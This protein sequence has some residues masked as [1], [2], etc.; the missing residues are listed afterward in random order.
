VPA[1]FGAALVALFAALPEVLITAVA[2]LALIGPLTGALGAA[3]GEER[4]RAAAVVTLVVTASGLTLFGIGA[5]FWGL[6]GGI[7]VLG[8]AALAR[9]FSS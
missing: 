7:C 1:A 8:L 2:G 5:P 6:A 3:L 4:D 9:R